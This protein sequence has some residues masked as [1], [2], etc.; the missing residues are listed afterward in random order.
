MRGQCV[1]SAPSNS[2]VEIPSN[3]S[4]LPVY[5]IACLSLIIPLI[6]ICRLDGAKVLIKKWRF[7][8]ISAAQSAPMDQLE[9]AIPNLRAAV[10]AAPR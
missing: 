9:A 10:A 2:A 1:G 8:P 6:L 5:G 7:N 3:T 4:A